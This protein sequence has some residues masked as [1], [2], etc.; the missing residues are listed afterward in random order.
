MKSRFAPLP[1]STMIIAILG[2]F[3][4]VVYVM[5]RWPSFGFAFML[6]FVVMFI[7]SMISMTYASSDDLFL[8][9]EYE[10]MHKGAVMKETRTEQKA[11][12]WID[13]VFGKNKE[14]KVVKKTKKKKSK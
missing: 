8:M 6:V 9:Q 3:I 14:E 2:F 7:A 12:R 4:S 5:K 11:E 1:S 10:T 13:K